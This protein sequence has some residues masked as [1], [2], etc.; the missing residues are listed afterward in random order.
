MG[1]DSR[2]GCTAEDLRIAE[3]LKKNYMPHGL[4]VVLAVA[5]CDLVETEDLQIVD[6]WQLEM[7][8]PMALAAIYG[9]GVWEIL[10]KVVD[11]GCGGLFPM[12]AHG[13]DRPPTVREDAVSVA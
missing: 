2:V 11:R 8:R 4:K 3:H 7:G 1:V 13:T 12:R 5:K 9:R 6:F 10:D